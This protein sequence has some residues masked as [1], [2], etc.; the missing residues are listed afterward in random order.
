MSGGRAFRPVSVLHCSWRAGRFSLMNASSLPIHNQRTS[1]NACLFSSWLAAPSLS[2][3]AP[4]TSCR[5][6]LKGLQQTGLESIKKSPPLLS[7]SACLPVPR[8]GLSSE[9]TRLRSPSGEPRCHQL[10]PCTEPRFSFCSWRLLNYAN[11]EEAARI[12]LAWLDRK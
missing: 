12:T 4:L 5:A 11:V 3:V 6:P 9:G 8:A 10:I 2:S 1:G 7:P